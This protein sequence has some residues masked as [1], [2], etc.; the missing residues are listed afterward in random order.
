M[1]G[2]AYAVAGRKEEARKMLGA[3]R[4]IMRARYVSPYLVAIVH[5]G[6]GDT[7]QTFEWLEKAYK[8]RAYWLFFIQVDPRM[9]E[10]RKDRRY[11]NLIRRMNFPP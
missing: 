2:R 1:L 6:L 5:A 11:T 10:L 7:E 9:N 8:E 4:E 3:L